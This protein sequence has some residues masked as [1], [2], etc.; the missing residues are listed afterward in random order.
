MRIKINNL[1]LNYDSVKALDSITLDIEPGNVT[2]IIG[3]NGAGKTSLLKSIASLLKPTGGSIYLD[4]KDSKLYKPKELAK[5]ISYSE[6]QITRS[7]PMKVLDFILTA[8]YP[9]HDVLHYFEGGRD[10]EVVNDVCNEL[11]VTHLLDRRLDEVSSGELQRIIIAAALAK[12]PKVLL[13]DEPSAYLDIR[14]RFEVLDHVRRYTKEYNITTVIALHDL[15]LTSIY[16]DKVVLMSGG[17]IVACGSPSEVL[18]DEAIRNVYGVEVMTIAVGNG[19][20][21]AVPKPSNLG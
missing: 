4:G 14:Y 15:H 2:C 17:R 6:A 8:R 19:S 9:F 20:V 1:S 5:I 12:R 21:I 3:P 13:L 16:C 11:K 7:I 10:L 18:T